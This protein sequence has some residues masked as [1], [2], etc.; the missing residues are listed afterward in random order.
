MIV[1]TFDMYRYDIPF[2][3]LMTFG[4]TTVS[5]RTGFVVSLTDADGNIGW[6]EVAPLP[7]FSRESEGDALNQLRQL[8]ADINAKHWEFDDKQSVR[9]ILD[10]APSN[11]LPSVAFGIEAALLNLTSS[12]LIKGATPKIPINSLLFGDRDSIIRKAKEQIGDGFRTLKLKIG[13]DSL[14]NDVSLI[15]HIRAEIGTKIKLRL[16]ANRAYDLTT[17]RLLFDQIADCSVE[18]IEEPVRDYLELMQLCRGSV[19]KV[20]IALDESL[21][22]IRP[23]S[24]I[25][26][27]GVTTIVLK[28]MLLSLSMSLMFAERAREIGMKSVISSSFETSLGLSTLVQF[29]AAISANNNTAAGLDTLASLDGDIVTTSLRIDRGMIDVATAAEISESLDMSKLRRVCDA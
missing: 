3:Q 1:K 16:D 24:L 28:P 20:P 5:N 19:P 29:A 23:E 26:L 14:E 17:A 22:S 4:K 25:A 9:T 13:R 7:F 27:R 12:L 2:K 15:K 11:L 21:R 10:S 8:A 18:Y 6:G